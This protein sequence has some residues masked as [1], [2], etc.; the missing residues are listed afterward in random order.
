MAMHR[1]AQGELIYKVIFSG[2]MVEAGSETFA[3]ILTNSGLKNPESGHFIKHDQ[4]G[5]L[6]VDSQVKENQGFTKSVLVV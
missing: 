3:I 2:K 4:I 1:T 5:E 6:R